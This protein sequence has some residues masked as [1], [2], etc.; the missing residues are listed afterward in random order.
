MDS[1][2]HTILHSKNLV[3]PNALTIDYATHWLYWVDT[4]LDMIEASYMDG[5]RRINIY[6]AQ[7]EE[8]H[9]F[10]LT[11]FRDKL[12][13]TDYER[14]AVMS[15]HIGEG[16]QTSDVYDEGVEPM[17]LV[18]VHPVRQPNGE[19]EGGREGGGGGGGEYILMHASPTDS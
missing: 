7:S 6:R 9:P 3:W 1:R 19:R 14:R 2:N 4:K 16:D 5:S 13:W 18:A 10:G 17:D 11:I 15:F 12:Y 8:F